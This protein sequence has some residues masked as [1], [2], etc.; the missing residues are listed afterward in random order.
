MQALPASTYHGTYADRSMVD[1]DIL[2]SWYLMTRTRL[3]ISFKLL[4]VAAGGVLS[5]EI[6]LC[7]VLES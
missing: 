5:F 4:M 2:I 1:P 6:T 7:H 3:G